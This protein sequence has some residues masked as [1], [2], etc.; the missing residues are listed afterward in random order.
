MCEAYP[1]LP[2]HLVKRVIPDFVPSPEMTPFNRHTRRKIERGKVLVHLFSGVQVWS[3]PSF[4]Y[5]LNMDKERGWDVLD[6]PTYGCLL[7]AVMQGHVAGILAGPPECI[8]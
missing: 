7:K 5:T 8:R 2:A 1:Q 6:G 4:N 3:H